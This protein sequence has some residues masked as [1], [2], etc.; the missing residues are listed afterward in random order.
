M[1]SHVVTKQMLRDL[2]ISLAAI[3]NSELIS[4]LEKDNNALGKI[5]PKECRAEAERVIGALKKISPDVSRGKGNIELSEEKPT[6]YWL[7]VIWALADLQWKIGKEIA[8]KW[9]QGSDRYTDGR[10]RSCL[11]LLRPPLPQPNQHSLGL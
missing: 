10:I 9:S 5:K 11:E 4:K 2:E 3:N 7:G 1:N 6:D 8:R